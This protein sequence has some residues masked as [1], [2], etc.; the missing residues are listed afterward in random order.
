MSQDAAGHDPALDAL[1]Q[2]ARRAGLSGPWLAGLWA[3]EG[4]RVETARGAPAENERWQTASLSLSLLDERGRLGFA[5]APLGPAG[6]S[7]DA[8]IERARASARALPADEARSLPERLDAFPL[9]DLALDDPAWET[10]DEG[11]GGELAARMEAAAWGE[12]PRVTSVRKPSFEAARETR[13]LCLSTGERASWRST[14]FAVQVEVAAR[15]GGS[16]ESSWAQREARSL[17]ALDPRAAG[18][19]ARARAVELLQARAVPTGTFPLLLDRRVAA[20]LLDLIAP[21]L[22]GDT[23]RKG[24]SLFARGPGSRVFSPRLTLVDDGLMPGGA[25]TQPLDDE[26][27]ARRTTLCVADGILQALLYDRATARRCGAATTG[28]GAAGPSAPVEPAVTNLYFRPGVETPGKLLSGISRGLWVRDA[29]GLHTADEVSGDFSVGCSGLWIENGCV[30]Y[31]VAGGTLSGNLLDLLAHV[32]GVGD[33]LAF[34]GS[35]GSPS[36]LVEAADLAGG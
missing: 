9:Q 35:L 13:V 8:L 25:D 10:L 5:Q 7:A 26:G 19:E 32:V 12:D 1:A 24:M 20:E 34:Q 17:S 16:A 31:P 28:N 36:L 15:Q 2:A 27:A 3:E 14:S 18:E 30:A 21:S 22:L 29:M 6:F 4:F 11:R 33:D 23:H